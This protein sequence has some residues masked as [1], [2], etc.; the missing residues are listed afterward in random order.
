M[1]QYMTNE[2]LKNMSSTDNKKPAGHTIYLHS[3]RDARQYAR[4]AFRGLQRTD[5]VPFAPQQLKGLCKNSYTSEFGMH[6]S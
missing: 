3:F 1:E 6:T 5:T 4:P 2:R